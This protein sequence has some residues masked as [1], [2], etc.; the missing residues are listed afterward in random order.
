MLSPGGYPNLFLTGCVAQCLK[1]YPYLR[2]FL[3]PKKAHFTVLFW[4]FFFFFFT[5]FMKWNPPLEIC[6]KKG[7]ISKDF[8][9]QK[10]LILLFFLFAILVKWDSLLNIFV[11]KNG[12]MS[13]KFLWKTNPFPRHIPVYLNMWVPPGYHFPCRNCNVGKWQFDRIFHMAI[14]KMTE[15]M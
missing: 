9:P 15:P 11:T 8:Q 13:K 12:P 5:F 6:W 14:S 2:I 4:F 3:P 10:Q 1:P 7:S